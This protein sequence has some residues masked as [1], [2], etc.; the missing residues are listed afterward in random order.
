MTTIFNFLRLSRFYRG[1]FLTRVSARYMGAQACAVRRTPH[2]HHFH[3]RASS[4]RNSPEQG[5]HNVAPAGE[6]TFIPCLA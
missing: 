1:S 4:I 5:R 2:T 6:L 3:R